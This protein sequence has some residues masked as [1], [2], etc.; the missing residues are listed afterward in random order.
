VKTAQD[1]ADYMSSKVILPSM[2]RSSF[3]LF[4]LRGSATI[5]RICR[6]ASISVKRDRRGFASVFYVLWL[7]RGTL[8]FFSCHKGQSFQSF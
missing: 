8:T 1:R 4:L 6:S 5:A 7:C 3:T 2:R